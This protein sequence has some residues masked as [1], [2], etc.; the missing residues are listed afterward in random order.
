LTIEPPKDPPRNRL[1]PLGGQIE[2]V[3]SAEP[4]LWRVE[5]DRGQLEQVLVNVAL[6][7]RDAM[8]AGGR[9]TIAT[10]NADVDAAYAALRPR[11]EPGRYCRLVLSDTGTGMDAATIERV[12]EPF[13]STKP[14]G[15]GTGLGLATVYGIV[16][17]LG[18]TIEIYSKQGLGTTVAVLLRPT[19][20][21]CSSPTWSCPACSAARLSAGSAPP[22]PGCPPSS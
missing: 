6:N 10:G 8:P 13:F 17:G 5:A 3:V 12:F 16:T 18:G 19:G 7:A 1:N 4:G 21:T 9:L 15:R 11:L 20:S 2:L 14:P 22:A